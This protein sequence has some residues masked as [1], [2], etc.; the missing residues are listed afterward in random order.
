MAVL[1][2]ANLISASDTSV[3]TD[4]DLQSIPGPGVVIVELQASAN[5]GTNGFSASLTLPGG[6]TPLNGM[7]IPAGVT[8]GGMNADDKYLGTFRVSQGGTVKL[9][10][11]EAGTATCMYRVTWKG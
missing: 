11:T 10:L 7:Q 9:A 3:L 8:A 6:A 5:D 2:V 4:T 1:T